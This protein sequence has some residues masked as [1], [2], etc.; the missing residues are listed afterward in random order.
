MS[1]ALPRPPCWQNLRGDAHN[2]ERQQLTL[3]VIKELEAAE[4]ALPQ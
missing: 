4:G 1:T 2:V 3:A